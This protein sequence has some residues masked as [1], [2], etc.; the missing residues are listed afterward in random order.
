M[1]CRS[2]AP[3]RASVFERVMKNL[4]SLSI[5]IVAST[6]VLNAAEQ[7]V[8]LRAEPFPL[9]SVRLL[10]GPFKERQDTNA[11]FLL[12][13]VEVDRLL[14]G[15][16]AQAGLP[17]KAKRYSGW[18]ARGI[19]GHSLGHYLSAVS[20]LYATTG[21]KR[22]LERVNYVVEELAECQK[23]NGDGYVLPVNKRVY[24]DLRQGKIKAAGFSLN[25]EW[26]PNYTL[27]KVFAGLRDAYRW[28][29]N[30][31]ALEVERAL[32]GYLAG[33]YKN[34][35]PQQAQEI[36]RSEH[37][38]MN[39]VFADLSVDTGDPR[40]L[41][42]ARTI[43]H[44]NAVL[45]PL[46][47]GRDELTGK[48]GNTQIPKVVGLAREYQLTGDTDAL[49]GVN[50]FWN[51]VVQK[52]S[53]ANGG[54]GESEHFFA[55]E[56]FPSKLSP[57]NAET[58]NSY[59]MIKLTG[60]MFSW[61]PRADEMDFVE[62]T[63]INHVFANIGHQPGEFGYFFGMESVAHKVF[64]KPA[65]GW[66]CC[67]G[68]GMENP[69][70]YGQQIYFRN[71]DALWV[72]LYMASELDWKERGVQIHQVTQF[73]EGD[74]V[75]FEIKSAKSGKF[76]LHLRHP[77]WCAKP[78]ISVNGRRVKVESQP[79]AY[80]TIDRTW[81]SGD[82][83]EVQ[84]PMSL[85]T[86]PLP[87]SDGKIVALMYGPMQLAAVV[88]PK[89][90]V[91]DPAKQRFADH[92][93]ARG[94]TDEAP[95]V[96]VA[97]NNVKLLSRIKADRKKFATFKSDGLIK[98][99]DLQLIPIHRVYEEHYAVYFPLLTK[100]EWVTREAEIRAA[101][102]RQRKL[103][104]AT[105]DVVQVG[106]QQ[107]EVEHKFASDRSEVG[108]F[109]D[110]KWRDVMPGGWFSYEMAVD[111]EKPMALLSTYWSDDRGREFELQ[112]DGKTIAVARPNEPRRGVFF[113]AAY[114]IPTE[115]TRGKRVVTVRLVATRGRVGSFGFRTVLAEAV[116]PEQWAAGQR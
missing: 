116:A 18:E 15:F 61:E 36:L 6:V 109:R 92:L 33:L 86:E 64:S 4:I 31:K 71:D 50:T 25:D 42:F 13:V 106:F 98:P 5:T 76:T 73:P 80:I 65:D 60:L 7:P 69:S 82:K 56:Q 54:H 55:P 57:Q 20:A 113:D 99:A 68:T 37:G 45:N 110:R 16:R 28:A 38:G 66:W 79:S 51:S 85:R 12:E 24:E 94:K 75:R 46:E 41:E 47:R 101:E 97:D 10:D 90:G 111:P 59:N 96:L 34:L 81:K 95:P 53:F 108:D 49:T 35:T 107:S 11:K 70:L 39:E 23:A 26:V 115:L 2:E 14:A 77:Y 83:I 58:C 102:A 87:H 8:P 74:S 103:D 21:D 19:N 17:E 44:H 9:S 43:F 104:A 63:L 40:Y 105:L 29:G 32:A 3:F 93:R 89:P 112:I 91:P 22:A 72:N 78:V 52:R 84:L 62:R 67:V 1:L 30:K 114:T 48:H 88:P 100:A 27:H